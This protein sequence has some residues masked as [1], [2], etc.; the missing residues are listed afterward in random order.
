MSVLTASALPAIPG[1]LGSWNEITDGSA[2]PV[3]ARSSSTFRQALAIP[4]WMSAS[5]LPTVPN[6]LGSGN[7][8][9][10]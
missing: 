2:D 3:H 7:E 4:I 6:E 1:E 9:I 8:I 5:A 10:D